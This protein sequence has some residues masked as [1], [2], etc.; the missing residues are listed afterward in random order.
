MVLLLYNE[1]QVEFTLIFIVLNR[2]A[3]VGRELWSAK[4]SSPWK[5]SCSSWDPATA[6]TRAAALLRGYAQLNKIKMTLLKWNTV[7]EKVTNR[8][9]VKMWSFIIY[10]Y[11][12]FFTANP[13]P[14]LSTPL[15]PTIYDLEVSIHYRKKEM[16]KTT[17]TTNR[18]Q[19]H[20]QHEAPELN[21]QH[22]CFPSTEGL[23]DHKQV[24]ECILCDQQKFHQKLLK[25][26]LL[27]V[28]FT[29]LGQ[30]CEDIW[31]REENYAK[32]HKEKTK[33]VLFGCC[34]TGTKQGNS[35]HF[36]FERGL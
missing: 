11:M 27:N 19:L 25:K 13:P 9:Y 33:S 21:A 12:V 14:A 10:Y 24:H 29:F 26:H 36:R 1:G 31:Y 6:V 15:Q 4:S 23:L 35:K 17:F 18:L 3:T 32:F 7:L 22:L 34:K 2:G 16:L 8:L 28:C 20:Y 5:L 30:F